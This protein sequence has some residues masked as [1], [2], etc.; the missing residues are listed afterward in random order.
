MRCNKD[1]LERPQKDRQSYVIDHEVHDSLGH[2]VSDGFVNDVHVGVHQVPYGLYLTLQLRVH[3][4]TITRTT[5]LP[6][7]LVRGRGRD[8]W[9]E[10]EEG[11]KGMARGREKSGGERWLLVV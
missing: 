4:E 11:E 2:E 1:G 8:G 10:R 9:L 5:T 6:I 7:H 3:R